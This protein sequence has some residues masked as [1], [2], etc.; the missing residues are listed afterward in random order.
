MYKCGCVTK[1]NNCGY[2]LQYT[3][4]SM[5]NVPLVI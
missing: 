5:I 4:E 1:R 3:V 2:I